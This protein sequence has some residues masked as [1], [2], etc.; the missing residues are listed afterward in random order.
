MAYM[1]SPFRFARDANDFP[2]G[3]QP[4]HKDTEQV[5]VGGASHKGIVSH[6]QWDVALSKVGSE[7]LRIGV[8]R[9]HTPFTPWTAR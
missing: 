4:A 3:I 8:S 2:V 5:F 7:V 6:E 9:H 1:P